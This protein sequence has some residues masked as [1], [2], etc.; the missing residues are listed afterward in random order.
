MFVW[1]WL[2]VFVCDL[3]RWRLCSSRG[4]TGRRTSNGRR[5]AVRTGSLEH[6]ADRCVLTFEYAASETLDCACGAFRRLERFLDGLLVRGHTEMTKH[7]IVQ[8]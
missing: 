6:L 4:R 2:L 8:R 1:R 7:A 5:G 3:Y